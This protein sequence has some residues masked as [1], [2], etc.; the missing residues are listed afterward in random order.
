MDKSRGKVIRSAGMPAAALSVAAFF[1]A[2]SSGMAAADAP[3]S[4]EAAPRTVVAA[5]PKW[6]ELPHFEGIRAGTALDFSAT[7]DAPAGKYGFARNAGGHIEFEGLPGVPQRFYGANL[8]FGAN[9]VEGDDLRHLVDDF[10]RMG[11][12]I[13]RLHH[14]DSALAPRGGGELDPAMLARIDALAAA[15][16]RRGIYIT[17][18]LYT[19]R[20]TPAL[21]E[22]PD[23]LA[24]N[25][26]RALVWAD[27]TA[28]ADFLAFA[29]NLLC[30][31]NPHTGL[32]WKD[33]P[34]IVD[35]DL[36][37]ED[38]P[39]GVLKADGA[40]LRRYAALF[41]EWLGRHPGLAADP[42]DVLTPEGREDRRWRAFLV[43]FY[44]EAYRRIAGELRAAGVRQMLSDLNYWTSLTTILQRPPLDIVEDH[45][46]WRHPKFPGKAWGFPAVVGSQS[47][48]PAFGGDLA[49][50]F[51]TR[52]MDKPFLVTEFDYPVPNPH[53]A[54]GAFLTGAYA[55]LQDWS[56]LVRFAWAHSGK[57]LT[58]PYQDVP[59]FFNCA[60]DP[61][62][63]LSEIAAILF[64]RRG[65]VRTATNTVPFVVSGTAFSD[66]G[67]VPPEPG[68]AIDRLGLVART[69][70]IV[71]GPDGQT[72]VPV[73]MP[74]ALEDVHAPNTDIAALVAGT[75][76]PAAA[77]SEYAKAAGIPE[78][79]VSDPEAGIWRSET[80]ELELV[81]PAS[82][83][84]AVT[85]R[86]EAFLLETGDAAE[87]N[88]ATARNAGEAP[89]AVLAAALDD[90]P[91][92]ASRRILLLGLSQSLPAGCAFS[93]ALCET[94]EDWG[95]GPMLVR[96]L[97]IDVSLRRDLSGFTLYPLLPDGT[98]LS[99]ES[100]PAL[101][102]SGVVRLRLAT[103]KAL[104]W[105]LIRE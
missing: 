16:K 103:E 34:A 13:V 97:E 22:A 104:A 89:C 3:A 21:P 95:T 8:C 75:Q 4:A 41:G 27:G 44:H 28:E 92:A 19:L 35:I 55:A 51:R 33:D 49:V 47:S 81:G 69:G 60:T 76:D 79:A 63:R 42:P 74:L 15:F 37:N 17:L 11:Y 94:V 12:N 83:F 105:E 82:R 102:E 88:V 39:E 31:V 53:A 38:S 80:G 100:L 68:A 56:G 57:A 26:Y 23:R 66:P 84:R 29:T 6:A 20:R 87:G 25:D 14:Y 10:A 1:F 36:V 5:G 24:R 78:D 48:I 96:R 32:A 86:S 72:P 73:Q 46:Y 99:A 58:P 54:E 43:E 61:L 70:T 101:D 98:R 91:L 67:D 30:H 64:F 18:D 7:L 90:K 9:F 59:G 71:V 65:D 85:P 93:D 52:L 62:R 40:A 50:A 45:F 2:A 77:Y